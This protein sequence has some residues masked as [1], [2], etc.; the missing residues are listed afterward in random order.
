MPLKQFYFSLLREAEFAD[1][2]T[3][4][5]SVGRYLRA[6]ICSRDYGSGVSWIVIHISLVSDR[7]PARAGLDHSFQK[8]KKTIEAEGIEY[9]V[10]DLLTISLSADIASLRAAHSAGDIAECLRSM[11]ASGKA[12]LAELAIPQFDMDAFVE[13]VM[14]ELNTIAQS[15]A[16]WPRLGGKGRFAT[17]PADGGRDAMSA[18]INEF[19]D[20]VL[21]FVERELPYVQD[22]ARRQDRKALTPLIDRLNQF[23][24]PWANLMGPGGLVFQTFPDCAHLLPDLG[25]EIAIECDNQISA[26]ERQRLHLE[27]QQRFDKCRDCAAALKAAKT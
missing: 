24:E 19:P 3:V 16:L 20:A 27:F 10:E 13:D 8:G 17:D 21:S 5:N 2:S 6:R 23:I 11:L 4:V 9:D 15:P 18:P 25:R 7:H 12:S 14:E 22:A 1:V 26:A